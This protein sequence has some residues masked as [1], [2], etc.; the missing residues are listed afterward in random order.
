MR[1]G[2]TAGEEF[3][4]AR[5]Y[6]SKGQTWLGPGLCISRALGDVNAARAGV[7]ATPEVVVHEIEQVE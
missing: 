2:S 6:E 1:P 3:C 4:V 7:V 5:V